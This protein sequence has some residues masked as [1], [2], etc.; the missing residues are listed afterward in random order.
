[1]L[2]FHSNAFCLAISQKS[3]WSFITSP[4]SCFEIP[5][6]FCGRSSRK[7][8]GR[9]LF[10][11][12]VLNN[13]RVE[14]KIHNSRIIFDPARKVKSSFLADAG[15]R[16]RPI[17]FRQYRN[18][19]SIAHLARFRVREILKRLNG[20]RSYRHTN[21]RPESCKKASRK[22]VRPRI[23]FARSGQVI[24]DLHRLA[25]CQAWAG[26]SYPVVERPCEQSSLFGSQVDE[27]AKAQDRHCFP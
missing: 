8:L 13:M 25:F 10:P 12:D 16:S 7:R 15:R 24:D 22:L 23:A 1:M 20:S 19:L 21:L 5:D 17:H 4:Q 2:I 6:E 14:L 27:H 9:L 3:V 18:P 11:D 26:L